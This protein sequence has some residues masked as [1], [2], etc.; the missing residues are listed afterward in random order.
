[1]SIDD[2]DIFVVVVVLI[3][4]IITFRLGTYY[5]MY[6]QR[7]EYKNEQANRTKTIPL[8]KDDNKNSTMIL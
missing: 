1:M 3:P 6:K 5:G 7:K 2:T 4:L 8:H